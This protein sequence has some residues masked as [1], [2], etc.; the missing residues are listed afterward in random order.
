[1]QGN[2]LGLG[3]GNKQT[4]TSIGTIY[5]FGVIMLGR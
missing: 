2:G 3:L 5:P 1:M 4:R